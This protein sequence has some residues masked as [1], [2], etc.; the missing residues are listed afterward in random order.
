MVVF[1]TLSE[2]S[3][4][5]EI[6]G[7]GFLQEWVMDDVDGHQQPGD[8]IDDLLPKR[9]ESWKRNQI[10]HQKHAERDMG[11]FIHSCSL[12]EEPQVYEKH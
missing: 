12:R 7:R 6:P 10:E 4:V 9:G 2:S 1:D 8:L 5:R 11:V 3:N